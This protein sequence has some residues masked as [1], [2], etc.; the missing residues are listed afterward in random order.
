MYCQRCGRPL[1]DGTGFCT[2]C[3]APTPYATTAPTPMSVPAAPIISP[4]MPP[5]APNGA[6]RT[7][8]GNSS[9]AKTYAIIAGV[10]AIAYFI[11]LPVSY[12]IRYSI[13][14]VSTQAFPSFFDYLAVLFN[15]A[16]IVFILGYIAIAI[17]A[18]LKNRPTTGA[19]FTVC[20]LVMVY[21]LVLDAQNLSFMG[22]A[23]IVVVLN[24][25]FD[26]LAFALIAVMAFARPA[27]TNVL[28]FIA[29][30]FEV[31][32]VLCSTI[33]SIGFT[34]SIQPANIAISFVFWACSLALVFCSGSWLAL[35][36]RNTN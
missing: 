6:V 34:G 18:F 9:S 8:A 35:T 11:V 12:L 31:L 7:A 32:A 25:V 21:W 30:G 5:A 14:F 26:L 27:S 36:A 4:T 1:P 19:G 17:G 33:L 15:P 2:Y 24:D 22:A 16:R 20:S 28:R 23:E 3:G 10:A 13:G 29:L